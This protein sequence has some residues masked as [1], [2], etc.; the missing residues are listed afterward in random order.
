MPDEKVEVESKEVEIKEYKESVLVDLDGTNSSV[1][2]KP[3]VPEDSYQAIIKACQMFEVKKFDGPG[4]ESKVVFAIEVSGEGLEEPVEL[5]LYCNPVI[6]KS[7]GTKGFSNSKLYDVLDKAGLL[8]Q[9]REDKAEL[10]FLGSL[11]SWFNVNLVGRKCKVLVKTRNRGQDNA[12]STVSD[13][14]RFEKPVGGI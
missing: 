1:Y 12:Y 3:L 14:V 8:N 9:A 10:A 4:K 2:E 13:I 5:P 11:V 6:K 7:S